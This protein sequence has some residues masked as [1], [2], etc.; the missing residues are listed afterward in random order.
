MIIRE[1]VVGY[2]EVVFVFDYKYVEKNEEE[3]KIQSYD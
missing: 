3:E 1:N 2:G